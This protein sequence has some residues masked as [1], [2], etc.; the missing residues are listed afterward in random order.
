MA[1]N[2]T[3]DMMAHRFRIQIPNS[4]DVEFDTYEEALFALRHTGV[5]HATM[6]EL[7][8]NGNV[9][10][11]LTNEELRVAVAETDAIPSL[12]VYYQTPKGRLVSDE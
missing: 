10:G 11:S 1:S 7:D 4:R 2:Y 6:V 9:H 3:R 8:E 5:D 12:S